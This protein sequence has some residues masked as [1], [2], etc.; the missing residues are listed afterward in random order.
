V[1]EQLAALEALAE[2]VA[3]EIDGPELA[4]VL[5]PAA[6]VID[7]EKITRYDRARCTYQMMFYR[8]NNT[9]DAHRDGH[10]PAAGKPGRRGGAG[11]DENAAAP[12]ARGP[13]IKPRTP[14][15][16]IAQRPSGAPAAATEVLGQQPDGALDQ[17][18]DGVSQNGTEIGPD[19]AAADHKG[20]GRSYHKQVAKRTV[21]TVVRGRWRDREPRRTCAPE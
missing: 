17:R 4:R 10:A 11:R 14:D 9:L 7:P 16:G 13:D 20:A 19:R 6:I 1:D 15:G 18:A 12:P 21:G 2:R 8:A 5:N 3:R